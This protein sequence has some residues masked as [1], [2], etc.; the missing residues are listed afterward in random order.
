MP[1]PSSRRPTLIDVS[2]AAEVSISTVSRILKNPG[3]AS[4]YADSTRQRVMTAAES[5]GYKPNRLARSTR[6]GRTNQIG[7][8]VHYKDKENLP[9]YHTLDAI[10]GAMEVLEPAG[11]DIVIIPLA[12]VETESGENSRLFSET[13]ID[14]AIVMANISQTFKK[15]VENALWGNLVWCDA[16]MHRKQLCVWR[17][18]VGAGR[19]AVE[20]LKVRNRKI[21]WL[22]RDPM[23]AREA[24]YRDERLE[25]ARL[26]AKKKKC[27]LKIIKSPH[28]HIEA[29]AYE[30]ILAE[31]Y[32]VVASEYTYGLNAF[33]LGLRFGFLP[34]R[35]YHLTCADDINLLDRFLPDFSRTS[36]DRIG[37]GRIAAKMLLKR[38]GLGTYP[39][40]SVVVSPEWIAGSSTK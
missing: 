10:T 14:G 32:D 5:I 12:E 19:L 31:G 7:V 6:S 17:D 11:F 35:D 8:V 37:M 40:K 15:R 21:A 22:Q 2:Q 16:N 20:N 25:G 24:Y 3:A 30:A 38:L 39:M 34:G 26:A 33:S 29:S 1:K 23:Y 9:S 36:F 18:E 13:F 28:D 4:A 27:S